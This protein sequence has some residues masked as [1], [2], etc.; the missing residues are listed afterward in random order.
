MRCNWRVI[1]SGQ[2]SN[3]TIANYQRGSGS[4]GEVK[5]WCRRIQTRNYKMK[6]RKNM[7]N[8]DSIEPEQTSGGVARV[9]GGL[10]EGVWD[11]D[12]IE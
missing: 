3:I 2:D 11:G 7:G 1:G 4:R 9:S 10:R 6:T 12:P 8:R 5:G